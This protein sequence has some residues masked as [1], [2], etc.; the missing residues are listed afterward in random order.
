MTGF[1]SRAVLI[2]YTGFIIPSGNPFVLFRFRSDLA[3]GRENR[4]WVFIPVRTPDRFG[5]GIPGRENPFF[6][7]SVRILDEDISAL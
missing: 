7:T 1:S 6:G 2:V 4:G 3:P 5:V